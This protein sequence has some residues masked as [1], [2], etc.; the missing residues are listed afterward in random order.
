MNKANLID[1]I[2]VKTGL[3]KR[4]VLQVLDAFEE[5]VIERL[6]AGD[7]VTLTGFGTFIAKFRSARGGVN[8]QKPE[9][10]IQVPAVTVPKFRAGKTL[11]DALKAKPV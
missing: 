8:P 5:V 4:Q 3:E 11:K 1:K 2:S 6:K 10:R 7:E 9:E